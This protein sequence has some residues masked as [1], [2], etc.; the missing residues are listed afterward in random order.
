MT[1]GGPQ[2]DRSGATSAVGEDK[3]CPEKVR[4]RKHLGSRRESGSWVQLGQFRLT[5]LRSRAY[6]ARSA[7][8]D[9]TD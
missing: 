8:Q 2:E 7:D 6:L 4:V 5:S 9:W 1:K 3:G